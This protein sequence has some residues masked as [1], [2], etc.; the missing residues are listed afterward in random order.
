MG[1]LILLI[2]LILFL[3]CLAIVVF[4][5]KD[6]IDS[7]SFKDSFEKSNLPII[8]LY[9]DCYALNF[10]IDTGSTFSC[11]DTHTLK[12]LHY[13]NTNA[14]REVVTVNGVNESPVILMTINDSTDCVEEL[15]TVVDMGNSNSINDGI[16]I[17]GILGS[18][19]CK[20]A[21]FVIDY[22]ELK[23]YSK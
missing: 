7:V 14:S 6:S 4:K 13:T 11:I 8:T 9:N 1:Y 10:L 21:N 15:F 20:R 16:T 19:F 22:N 17:H 5:K 2:V 23:V 12:Y 18:T 3:A